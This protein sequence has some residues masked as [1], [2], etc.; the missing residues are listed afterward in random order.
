MIAVASCLQRETASS[1]HESHRNPPANICRAL[2]RL[3]PLRRLPHSQSRVPKISKPQSVR[4][5]FFGKEIRTQVPSRPHHSKLVAPCPIVRCFPPQTFPST[6]ISQG[7]K[8]SPQQSP[9]FMRITYVTKNLSFSLSLRKLLLYSSHGCHC[10][11]VWVQPP[12]EYVVSHFIAARFGWPHCLLLW[13]D[14]NC[15][16]TWTSPASAGAPCF[17]LPS[18]QSQWKPSTP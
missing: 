4:I 8:R 13:I 9:R 7:D 18:L 5:P 2:G 17:Y 1:L 6:E 15:C 14:K 11:S 10:S 3:R 12:W 16:G